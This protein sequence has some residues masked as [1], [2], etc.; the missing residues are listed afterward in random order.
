LKP[1]ESESGADGVPITFPFESISWIS[2]NC[3]RFAG[4]PFTVALSNAGDVSFGSAA[5]PAPVPIRSGV[6]SIHSAVA[7]EELYGRSA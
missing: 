2:S 6:S 5:N 7:C 1:S 4:C 3:W